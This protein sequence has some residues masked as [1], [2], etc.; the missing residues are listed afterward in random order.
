MIALKSRSALRSLCV[1]LFLLCLLKFPIVI[2]LPVLISALPHMH[3]AYARD[4]AIDKAFCLEEER[5]TKVS[6][7][8]K[9]RQLG[10]RSS[11]RRQASKE[12]WFQPFRGIAAWVRNP[13]EPVLPPT[14]PDVQLPHTAHE[15]EVLIQTQQE[16]LTPKEAAAVRIQA[17]ARGATVR[18]LRTTRVLHGVSGTPSLGPYEVP[19]AAAGTGT[20][21]G[22]PSG[23]A[24]G[25][26]STSQ[27]REASG[28]SSASSTSASAGRSLIIRGHHVEF[29]LG[30]E[31]SD[32]GVRSQPSPSEPRSSWL[33]PREQAPIERC[34][35]NMFPNQL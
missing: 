33:P 10:K 31:A 6:W 14:A 5:I 1:C 35:L 16:K 20:A 19:A 26:A 8:K 12:R 7:I 34:L 2:G 18:R 27:A 4:M 17:F 22:A 29:D 3:Y 24:P 9:V 28:R 15:V 21:P 23:S 13:L 25:S 30:E 11:S 32:P